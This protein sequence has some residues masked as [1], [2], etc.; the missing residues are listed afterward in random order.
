[1]YC[2][3]SHDVCKSITY[4]G[5]KMLSWA[6]GRRRVSYLFVCWIAPVTHTHH[7]RIFFTI[8]HS[9]IFSIQWLFWVTW[10]QIRK[11]NPS[12]SIFALRIASDKKAKQKSQ[13]SEFL[14]SCYLLY[15]LNGRSKNKPIL[16]NPLTLKFGASPN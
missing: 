1:M 6:H 15:D 5:I 10:Q 11:C 13:R 8:I 14:F 16:C 3:T 4:Y 7:F 12:A 9:L 2:V